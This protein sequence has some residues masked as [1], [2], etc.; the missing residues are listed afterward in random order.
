VRSMDHALGCLLGVAVGDASGA[1]LEGSYVGSLT[2]VDPQDAA[3]AMMMP[4]EE[5]S[6][7]IGKGRDH[8]RS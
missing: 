1:L 3:A 2:P 4:G 6:L 5:G 7:P 8:R